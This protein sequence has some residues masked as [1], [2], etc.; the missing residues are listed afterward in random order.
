VF[1]VLRQYCEDGQDEGIQIIIQQRVT[2]ED[3]GDSK[4][5]DCDRWG[6]CQVACW[7]AEVLPSELSEELGVG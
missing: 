4:K 2:E 5:D 3:T 7:V 1:A 6:T